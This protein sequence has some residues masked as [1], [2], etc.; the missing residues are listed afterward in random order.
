MSAGE[1]SVRALLALGVGVELVCCVGVLAMR[2]A[3]DRLHFTGPA[4]TL[5]PLAIAA[6]V[7]LEESLWP[8]GLKAL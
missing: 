5:G 4:S 2:D 1:L 3:Y 8:A 6:A 7:I